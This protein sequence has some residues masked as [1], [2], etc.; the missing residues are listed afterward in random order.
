MNEEQLH[1]ISLKLGWPVKNGSI[2]PCEARS[3]EKAKQLVINKNVDDS[4]KAKRAGK[5]YF[6]M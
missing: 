4:K 6:Q 5:E 2:V 1:I 3:I